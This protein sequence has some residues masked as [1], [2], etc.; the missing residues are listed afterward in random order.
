MGTIRDTWAAWRRAIAAGL[1][2]AIVPPS[3]A[4]DAQPAPAGE[5]TDAVKPERNPRLQ[6]PPEPG[7][8]P[9]I[10][11]LQVDEHLGSMLPSD[12]TFTDSDGK[13]VKLGDYFKG[14]KPAVLAMVYYD[15]P[16][17]CDVVMQK[18]TEC[19][20]KMDL[21]LGDDYRVL[22]FSF[23]PKEGPELAAAKREMY[24]AMYANSPAPELA[25]K[26]RDSWKLHTGEAASSAALAKALGFKYRQLD[27]GEYNHPVATY[28]VSPTG[29]ITRYIHGF[30]IDPR[31][32]KLSLIAASEGTIRPSIGDRLMSFCYMLDPKTGRYTVQIFRLMQVAGAITVA[33]VGVGIGLLMF[34]D[35]TRKR[36]RARLE[37][38]ASTALR[39]P[40]PNS[41]GLAS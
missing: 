2:L 16:L 23:D 20:A 5:Q 12:I 24:Y 26:L 13:P 7:L 33:V 17:V 1:L 40:V 32:V 35:Q 4:Q 22:W 6:R 18:Q 14:D 36:S 28:I 11:G 25:K 9:E 39:T 34:R 30:D 31:D 41:T 29:K 3:Q 21:S 37:A 10:D 15:C 38:A 8:P 19:F 27:T